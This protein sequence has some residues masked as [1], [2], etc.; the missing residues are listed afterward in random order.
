MKLLEVTQEQLRRIIATDDQK[1]VRF[2]GFCLETLTKAA[3]GLHVRDGTAKALELRVSEFQA[4][5]QSSS[6]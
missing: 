3:C 4:L 1:I 2:S 6:I 5:S